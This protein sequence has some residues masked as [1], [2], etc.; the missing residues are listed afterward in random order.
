MLLRLY[1]VI[2]GYDGSDVLKGVDLDVE[3][4]SI[5]C[6]VGPNGAGKST[7]LRVISGLLRPR[8]GNLRFE[9][10]TLA[11]LSPRQVLARGI[12]QVPQNHSLFPQM[13]VAE[14]VRLGA[15]T[16]TDT[17][18]VERRLREVQ[19][20][21]PLVKERA[22]ERAG[23]LSG[24]QQRLVEFARCLMLDPKVVLL[25][26]PS[27]GLDPRTMKQVFEMITL[28]RQT[29]RTILLVAQNARSGLRI[30]THGV[31]MESGRVH[32]EG[33]HT[34]ILEN[35]QIGELYLGG[36]ISGAAAG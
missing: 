29:G 10:R 21:F 27:M 31:V 12:V 8:Q 25:D 3:K 20:L 17:A 16:V 35:P 15:Y 33:T 19:D 7:V 1:N 28:M 11:G 36:L 26:E 13:S 22:R 30:S 14:N 4:E 6:I 32:L 23:S 18:L 2:A 24:G 34:E 5:T 9:G